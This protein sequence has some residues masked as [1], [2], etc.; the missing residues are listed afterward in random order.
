MLGVL[1]GERAKAFAALPP[2]TSDVAKFFAKIPLGHPVRDS[3]SRPMI[4]NVAVGEQT[5]PSAIDVLVGTLEGEKSEPILTQF[6]RR[7]AAEHTSLL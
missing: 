6:A 5:F 1:R 3:A 7:T 4:C 2:D